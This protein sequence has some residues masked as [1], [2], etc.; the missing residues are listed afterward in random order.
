MTEPTATG[1]QLAVNGTL[2]RGFPLN[3]NL[4]AL[5]ATFVRTD[6]TAPVYRLWSIRGEHPAMIRVTDGSGTSVEVEVWNVPLDA[7][8]HILRREPE[9][10]ALGKVHLADG[11]TMLGV[12]AEPALVED[13]PEITEFG[14]WRAYLTYDRRA[15]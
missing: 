10:L 4:L 11:D 5:G 13:A 6:R 15:E 8:A 2:M 14:G 3:D 9:G 7:L 12:L 1:V